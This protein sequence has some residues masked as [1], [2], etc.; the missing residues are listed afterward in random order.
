MLVHFISVAFWG[1]VFTQL[2]KTI[3]RNRKLSIK[4]PRLLL[5]LSIASFSIFVEGLYFGAIS[6]LH[7]FGSD[8]LLIGLLKEENWFLVKFLIALSGIYLLFQLKNTKE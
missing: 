7:Y 8:E 1:I 2:M 3:L 4:Q 5:A 6:V